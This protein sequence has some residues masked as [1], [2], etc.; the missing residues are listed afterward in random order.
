MSNR[1]FAPHNKVR[2]VMATARPSTGRPL[3][4]T[5]Q[6][7]TGS[8][9]VPRDTTPGFGAA[10]AAVPGWVIEAAAER[11]ASELLYG[12]RSTKKARINQICPACGIMRSNAGLCD[13]NS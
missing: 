10:N 13:C 11:Q 3:G 1:T 8:T 6:D 5:P 2:K 12:K 9:Y 4:A 7:R